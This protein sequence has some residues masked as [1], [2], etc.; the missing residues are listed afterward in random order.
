MPGGA[1]IDLAAFLFG[2]NVWSNLEV[3]AIIYK[4]SDVIP[5]VSPDRHAG[6]SALHTQHLDA[7]LPLLA[8]TGFCDHGFDDE[9]VAVLGQQVPHV[10]ELGLFVGA[11][12]EEPGISV[13]R[14]FVRLIAQLLAVKIDA[15]IVIITAIVIAAIFELE[16]FNASTSF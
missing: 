9:A 11:F 14:G 12:P 8:G 4:I 5:F 13:S 3:T 2:G 7:C 15:L 1:P 10:A 6:M 16:L